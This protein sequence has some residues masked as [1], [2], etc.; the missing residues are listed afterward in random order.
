MKFVCCSSLKIFFI[1]YTETKNQKVLIKKIKVRILK[2]KNLKEALS[3]HFANSS[4]EK[5]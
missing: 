4:T 2:L 5:Y 1:L 3:N